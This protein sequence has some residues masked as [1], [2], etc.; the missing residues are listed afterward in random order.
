VQI[1]SILGTTSNGHPGPPKASSSELWGQPHLKKTRMSHFRFFKIQFEICQ[2]A[3]FCEIQLAKMPNFAK[4]NLKFA[5]KCQIMPK[6]NLPIRK[7]P[8]LQNSIWN[9]QNARFA[10]FRKTNN[11]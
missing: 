11:K 5:K 2:N 1:W 6:F 9:F 3:R 7:C 10:R 4:F 8:I